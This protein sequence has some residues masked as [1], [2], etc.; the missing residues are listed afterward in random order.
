MRT[1]GVLCDGELFH[2]RKDSLLKTD[3]FDTHGELFN[4]D[5]YV[6]KSPV[7]ARICDMFLRSLAGNYIQVTNENYQGL[8]TLSQE[9]EYSGFDDA[10]AKYTHMEPTSTLELKRAVRHTRDDIGSHDET[11]EDVMKMIGDLSRQV[12]ALKRQVSFVGERVSHVEVGNAS[13]VKRIQKV[14]AAMNTRHSA[15]K[16]L[17]EQVTTMSGALSQCEQ[18]TVALREDHQKAASEIA[19]IS[20][21]QKKQDGNLQTYIDWVNGIV[22]TLKNIKSN[23]DSAMDKVDRLDSE[24]KTMSGVISQCQKKVLALQADCQKAASDISRIN[25]HQKQ[26]DGNIQSAVDSVNGVVRCVQ[27]IK[28]NN[29]SVT[30][31]VERLNREVKALKEAQKTPTHVQAPPRTMSAPLR[32]TILPPVSD[33]HGGRS[34]AVP[35]RQ[36][37][38][39]GII[40][41]LWRD[42][43][44]DLSIVAVDSIGPSQHARSILDLANENTYFLSRRVKQPWICLEFSRHRVAP[45]HYTLRVPIHICQTHGYPTSWRFEVRNAQGSWITLDERTNSTFQYGNSTATF[46]VQKPATEPYDFVRLRLLAST[47]TGR[48]GP[49]LILSGFEIFGQVFCY[50]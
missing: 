32:Q 25:L 44:Q 28:S 23:S 1:F 16:N 5:P 37:S 26:Q 27:T 21:Q 40:T 35:W 46:E 17:R 43:G 30:D 45:T 9:F 7:S 42:N 41:R 2:V 19:R 29:D 50:S 18:N 3:L 48:G 20:R 6:V 33:P 8:H 14:V 12:L 34:V 38:F 10:F 13:N 24:A 11:S 49:A 36:S 47:D 22:T 39:D 31:K 4:S 15:F